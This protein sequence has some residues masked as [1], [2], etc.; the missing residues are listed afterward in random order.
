M[1]VKAAI[2][3]WEEDDN[4]NGLKQRILIDSEAPNKSTG[5]VN[6]QSSNILNWDDEDL[7]V[8]ASEI[9]KLTKPMIIAANKSDVQSSNFYRV[10]I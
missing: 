5:I 6:G 2:A 7:K 4:M 9:R 8:L 3:D 10:A 1:N